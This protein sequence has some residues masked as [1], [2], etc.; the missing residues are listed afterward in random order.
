MAPKDLHPDE[1]GP[2]FAA[3]TAEDLHGYYLEDLSVG[4]TGV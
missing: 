3:V 4:M 2:S 1:R